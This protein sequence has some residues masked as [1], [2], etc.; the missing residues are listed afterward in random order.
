M[1]FAKLF[2]VLCTTVLLAGTLFTGCIRANGNT[3]HMQLL[4]DGGAPLPHPP[5]VADGGAPLPHPPLVADG[6]APLPHPPLV[7]FTA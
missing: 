2:V 7:S 5:L 1:R 4:A 3:R 6:G